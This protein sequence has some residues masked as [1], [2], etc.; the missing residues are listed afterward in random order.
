MAVE[1]RIE[2]CSLN[3]PLSY[4]AVLATLIMC[5][6]APGAM[7]ADAASASLSKTG[8]DLD[9]QLFDAY[10]RCELEKFGSL[11]AAEVEFYHD[12][13]GLMRSRD[14]VVE[15]VRKN[16]CGKVRRELVDSTLQT[17]PM[18]DYGVV[19]LG[20]HRFCEVGAS[21]CAGVAR[22][23]HLWQNNGGVWTV[24]RIISYDHQPIP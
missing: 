10:N 5:V 9:R 22:F 23:V 14:S 8:A 12:Q 15:A 4:G 13:G 21:K 24:T 20:D 16:I 6:A 18:K 11:L 1:S 2:G 17:F 3:Q 7:A 19:Q